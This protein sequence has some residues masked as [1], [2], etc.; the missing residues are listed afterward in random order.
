MTASLTSPLFPPSPKSSLSGD[1]NDFNVSPLASLDATEL[2]KFIE[3]GRGP[4]E[5]PSFS[6]LNK[7]FEY[8]A[9]KTPHAIAAM[10]G[11][12]SISYQVLNQH[13]EQLATFL[14]QLGVKPGDSVGLFLTRSIPMLTGMMACLKI[15]AN[16]VPQHAGVAPHPQLEHIVETA[17]IKIVLTLSQHKQSLPAF[18]DCTVIEL[19]NL[20]KS[21]EFLSL[22]IAGKRPTKPQHTCFI[23]FTS[24]T[25]GKPNGVQV[26][27]KNV[28]NIV[29]TSPGNLGVKPGMRVAQILSIA[30]DMSAWEVFV[31]LCHGATLLIR[32]KVIEHTAVNADV[33]IATPSVL[34]QIDPEKCRDVSV[35]AVA[36]EP[37]PKPLADTWGAFC[38]FYNCCGPTETTIINTAKLYRPGDSLTIGKPTPNNTV[39]V[40]NEKLEPCAIGEVGEMWAGGICVTKGYLANA[41]LSQ[42]R[43]RAD[44][45]LGDGHVMFRTRDLGRW[46]PCGELEHYGRTDDQVK[47]K[48]FRVELDAVS[49]I[50]EQ[51]PACRLAVTLKADANHLVSFVAPASV[52]EQDAINHVASHLP[53][54]CVPVRVMAFETLPLTPRGKIDK[55]ALQ[56]LYDESQ[57]QGGKSA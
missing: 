32:D 10:H 22:K 45:F 9:D 15:G 26:T 49:S 46:T 12:R 44:P 57:N 39:Y 7:A 13:A 1:G 11:N 41:D 21:S 17:R 4:S 24:G 38:D 3:F 19:D 48:G 14:Q 53:Y 2:R 56:A 27:H 47:V 50:I 54:Y 18:D 51:V 6:T 43:Y 34:G 36:G 28:C 35:V 30:F 23:L 31:A 33:I 52:N 25:T 16:Y 8:H 40:L 37:C 29:M 5:S 20:L 55:R 42:A